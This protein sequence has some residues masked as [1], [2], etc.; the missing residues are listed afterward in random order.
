MQTI[1]SV[2][3]NRPIREVF[4]Y[5]VNNVAECK[6]FSGR[7]AGRLSPTAGN[8]RWPSRNFKARRA[9][10]GNRT[11]SCFMLPECESVRT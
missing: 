5:T 8:S 1:M 10:A 11:R 7:S 2:E 9:R 3:I 6:A 4:D